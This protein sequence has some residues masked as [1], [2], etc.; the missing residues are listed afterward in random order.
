MAKLLYQGHGSYRI[1]A[2]NGIVI[3][4]DPFAGEGYDI[5]AD[6]V[7]ITHEHKDH[8]NLELIT[9][10]D[11]CTVLRSSDML[12][13]GHYEKKII[14][15]ITI[16]AVPAYNK[17]HDR[18]SCVGYVISIDGIKVYG[19]G[20]TSLTEYMALMLSLEEID[21]A[22]LPIDGVYNMDIPEAERCAEVINA[23]HTIPIHMKP[24]ELFDKE[25]ADSF[26]G[27]NK[28]VVEPGEELNL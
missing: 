27:K 10:K 13:V 7:L 24:G 23:K 14:S 19:A 4:V 28:L 1:T 21:Y 9:Q 15:G 17:N 5:P 12:I 3:Y 16:E 26:K 6:I 22:L 18:A 2:D 11:H 25:R 8:N 20:D